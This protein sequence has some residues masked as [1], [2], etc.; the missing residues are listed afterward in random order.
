MKTATL[1]TYV[2][3]ATAAPA[4]RSTLADR[5]ARRAA[6]LTRPHDPS[7]FIPAPAG[8]A[9][10]T[11]QTKQIQ[12]SSNWAGAVRTSPPAGT[13]YNRV[14]GYFNVPNPSPPPNA[15]PGSYAASAWAGI[16]GDTYGAAILQAGCDFTADTNG[17]VGT[18]C[19]YE[20]YPQFLIDFPGFVPAIGDTIYVNIVVTSPTTGT[21]TLTNT[22]TGDTV[23]QQLNA[24]SPDATLAGQNAEWI[25]EDFSSGGGLVPFAN[26]GQVTF[27]NCAAE[28]GGQTV[29]TDGAD[30][31]EITQDGAIKTDVQ[32][33]DG[34][35]VQ[36]T[37]Q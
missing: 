25:V 26:F 27:T 29:G 17:A 8:F 31:I 16:D 20:Y 13:T 22:R 18:D 11:N 4:T 36:V 23:T 1:L 33:L 19:W 9:P 5:I 10:D 15:A 7:P 12:Y 2:G 24:P 6:G 3:L 28:A 32:I 37:Y 14:S 35:T 21:T 30:I 34:A